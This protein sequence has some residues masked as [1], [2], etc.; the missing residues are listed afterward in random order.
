[1]LLLTLYNSVQERAAAEVIE[2][3]ELRLIAELVAKRPE[4]LI[5]SAR[6]LLSTMTTHIDELLQNRRACHEYFNRLSPHIEGTFRSTG[7]ILPDGELHCNSA[8]A[9]HDVRINVGDRPYFRMALESGKFSVGE[10]QVGY[11]SGQSGINFAY[12]VIDAENRV[13]AV[14]FAGLNLSNFIEQGESQR[15]DP[16]TR[17]EGRVITILDRNDI[18]LARYP[19]GGVRVGEKGQNPRML[20]VLSH[21]RNGVFAATDATGIARLYAVESVGMNPDSVPPIRVVVSKPVSVV[22]ADADRAL[23]RTI[24]G[25]VFVTLLMLVAAWFGAEALVLRRFRLLLG[26]A[27]R[28]RTG[29]LG[30]RT[31]FGNGRE[32]LTQ[33]G[34]AFDAMAG[35]LQARD[36]QL[37]QVLQQLNEQAV[38]DQLTGL[39]N[40]RYLWDVFEAELSRARRKQTPLAVMMLD[41]DHFKNFNDRWGHEAGD[42]VLKNVADALRR[43]VR[44]SDIV[45]RHGGEEFVI[46]LPEA[47]E[48]VARTRAEALRKEVAALRLTYGGEALEAVT[49]SVGVAFSTDAHETAEDLVRIADDAMYEAKQ[50][51]RDRVVFRQTRA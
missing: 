49:V 12:P 35:E 17:D 4:Q 5:Q 7:V 9:N 38:T 27:D 33:L 21:A 31:G 51:G 8:I 18:V 2:R 30:A 36:R 34:N 50:T 14:L 45:A 46:V 22:F 42:L 23:S 6:Q 41:V 39:P 11:T 43:V 16:L 3:D 13:R 44:G 37:R 40:R 32:E 19:G 1:M 28:V 26:M 10:Y 24:A 47:T 25:I 48:D 29:D 20:E 15:D